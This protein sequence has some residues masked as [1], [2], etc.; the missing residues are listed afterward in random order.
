[1]LSSSSGKPKFSEIEDIVQHKGDIALMISVDDDGTLFIDAYQLLDS[2]DPASHAHSYF[3]ASDISQIPIS[4]TLHADPEF[5]ALF[6]K[7]T[8][9]FVPYKQSAY[10]LS[11]CPPALLSL[12]T[13]SSS[14][15]H[16]PALPIVPSPILKT[17][18]S[19]S[20]PSRPN[21]VRFAETL[22][23]KTKPKKK[24]KP[25]TIKMCPVIASVDER[26]RIVQEIKG[27]PL[28]NLPALPTNPLK[29]TPVGRYT[30]EC[31]EA[32]DAIHKEGFLEPAECDLLHHFVS[33]HNDGF[34]WNDS[35]QGHF[36]E[37]FFP[38]VE[39][40]VVPHKPWVQRNIPIPPGIHEEVCKVLQCK[41]DA[42]IM[43]PSNSSYR[44][45]WFCVVKKDRKLRVIQSLELLNAITIAHSGI[46]PFTDHLTKQFTGRSCGAM[47]DLF[48]G[49]D[50]HAIAEMSRDL[51]TF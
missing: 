34:A 46:P 42:G 3:T 25:V 21:T 14:T 41:I 10:S 45:H 8:D 6:N 51:M 22:L 13:L 47:M 33:V 30:Q 2:S 28:E 20:P 38:P 12:S 49:Y 37:D 43:E 1:M 26:F 50:E 18:T 23:T 19:A 24:Y 16:Q 32:F 40:P 5:I 17:N 7:V 11:S 44:S 36:C 29:F 9:P 39:I 35:E 4:D 31:M 15:S 27:D 48:I